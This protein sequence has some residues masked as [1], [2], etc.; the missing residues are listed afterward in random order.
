MYSWFFLH[1]L[2]LIV[3]YLMDIYKSYIY[4]LI[5]WAAIKRRDN[6]YIKQLLFFKTFDQCP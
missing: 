5:S 6:W 4:I 2:N 1:V 3:I